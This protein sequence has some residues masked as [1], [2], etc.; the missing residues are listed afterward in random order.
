MTPS[1]G[2]EG[3]ATQREERRGH[4]RDP[5]PSVPHAPPPQALCSPCWAC[6]LTAHLLRSPLSPATVIWKDTPGTLCGFGQASE[7]VWNSVS[8]TVKWGPFTLCCRPRRAA[9][10]PAEGRGVGGGQLPPQTPQPSL[11]L[12]EPPQPSPV[13]RCS[14]ISYVNCRDPSLVSSTRGTSQGSPPTLAHLLPVSPGHR[15]SK[16]FSKHSLSEAAEGTPE[17][18]LL[19]LGEPPELWSSF[20]AE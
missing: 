15:T 2:P 20:P 13:L 4:S 5:T 9:E 3:L 11:P 12:P 1:A 19:P 17:H 10:R 7:P 18:H 16:A 8:P 14:L 6:I